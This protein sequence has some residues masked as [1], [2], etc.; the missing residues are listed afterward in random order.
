[1]INSQILQIR[2]K[3]WNIA[4]SASHYSPNA[5]QLNPDG[6]DHDSWLMTGYGITMYPWLS[7]LSERSK[8]SANAMPAR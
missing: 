6:A 3:T 4:A 2:P 1:M 5:S 7:A 8:V